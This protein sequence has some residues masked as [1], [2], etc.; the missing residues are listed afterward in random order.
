MENTGLSNILKLTLAER[1]QLVEDIWDSIAA[2]PSAVD[3]TPEQSEE[4]DRRLAQY[5]S[6]P[7]LVQPWNSLR[8][9]LQSY[10]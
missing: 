5:H 8:E 10:R 7:H 1:I 3:L 9:E 4:L 2:I 6:D